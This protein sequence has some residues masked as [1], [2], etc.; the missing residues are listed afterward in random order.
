MR[1][2]KFKLFSLLIIILL[3][4][5]GEDQPVIPYTSTSNVLE[6]IPFYS[7]DTSSDYKFPV[8]FTIDGIF[9]ED[10]FKNG[11]IIEFS[12]PRSSRVQLS[13]II[14]LNYGPVITGTCIDANSTNI[15]GTKIINLNNNLSSKAIEIKKLV[16]SMNP[17]G[18]FSIYWDKKSENGKTVTEG[19]YGLYMKADGFENI[20]L[21]KI[22]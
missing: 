10:Q 21:F 22:K 19:L 1:S 13:I 6:D 17:A 2:F 7:P 18:K 4:H 14:P 8:E 16:D 11:I 20:L 15:A 12:L 3:L 5:C 9:W